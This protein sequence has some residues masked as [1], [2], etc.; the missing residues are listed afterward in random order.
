MTEPFLLS[1]S[2]FV[3]GPIANLKGHYFQPSL[4]VC[5]WPALQPFNIDRF[6]WN[7]VTRTLLWSS[8]AATIMV[9][10]GGWGTARHLYENFKKFSKSPNSNFK[11]LVHHCVCVSCVS[12]KKLDSTWTK[13]TEEIDFEVFPYGDY[14]NGTAAAARRSAGYCDWTGGEAACSDRSSGAFRTG[15]AIGP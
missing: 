10:I 11:I 15:G 2:V 1:I 13:V 7:F 9:Q 6:W 14:A 5:L 8:L 4:S 12:Y 3:F